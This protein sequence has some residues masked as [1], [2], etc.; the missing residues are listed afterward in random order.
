M[1][2]I[3]ILIFLLLL[4][5]NATA[6]K[7]LFFAQNKQAASGCSDA[8]ASAYYTATGLSANPTYQTAL[9][10]LVTD[11]KAQGNWSGQQ[12]ITLHVNGSAVANAPN[13]RNP[14]TFSTT[15]TPVGPISY[16]IHGAKPSIGGYADFGYNPT[17][18]GS[19][20]DVSMSF[21]S[22]E[23]ISEPSTDYGVLSGQG[24]AFQL[25]L[26]DIYAAMNTTFAGGTYLNAATGGTDGWFYSERNGTA[27]QIRKNTT[28]LV[29]GTISSSGQ[30]NA[31]II[32]WTING[33][34]YS[35][36][37]CMVTTIGSILPNPDAFY[38]SLVTFLTTIGALP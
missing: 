18:H 25:Y 19:I 10:T 21:F 23:N 1:K 31:N 3:R 7:N 2:P 30:P 37:R 4:S 17:T 28:Q 20:N 5:L 34:N 32:V 13:L 35:T 24:L 12:V 38:N 27:V 26:G 22:Y 11:W 29:S 33:S 8:D 16:T 6:Q 15:Y 36:K 9:C 14:A